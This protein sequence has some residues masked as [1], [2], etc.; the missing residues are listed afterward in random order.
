MKIS[1][2]YDQSEK[3]MIVFNDGACNLIT[4]FCKSQPFK[5]MSDVNVSYFASKALFI[6]DILKFQN[7]KIIN[8]MTS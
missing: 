6:L 3:K 1:G 7:F 2:K 4:R 5:V 8:F